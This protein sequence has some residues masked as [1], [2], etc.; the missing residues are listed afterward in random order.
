MIRSFLLTA[1]LLHSPSAFS[2][3]A[4]P[5]EQK[6]AE[7]EAGKPAPQLVLLDQRLTKT[8]KDKGQGRVDEK[9][10]Q[11]F[12]VKFRADLEAA[13]ARVKPTPPNAALHARILSRLGDSEQA[14]SALG[15]ALGQDPDN[16]ALRVGLGHIHYDKKDYPAALAEANAVLARDPANKDALALKYS[17]EGRIAPGGAAP[18]ATVPGVSGGT[19]DG[20]VAVTEQFRAPRA[21]DSPKVQALVPR[22][23][24]ARG[25]GDMRTAMSLTQE[26]MRTEPASE[27]TQEIY[28][29]VA[30]DYVSWQRDQETIGYIYSAKAA[31]KA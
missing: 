19:S 13:M 10:Y 30:K 12:L 14:M 7:Q 15:P 6:R 8:Q 20:A 1:T 29:I 21:M 28:R 3:D 24:D 17:S 26:L 22:I 18:S 11:E 31:L 5:T 4:Q 25:S 23:R 27:Y 2:Q 16:P 9:R